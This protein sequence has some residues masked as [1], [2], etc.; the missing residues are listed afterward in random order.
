MLRFPK[1]QGK[2]FTS[3]CQERNVGASYLGH[4]KDY[5]QRIGRNLQNIHPFADPVRPPLDGHGPND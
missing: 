3:R 2:Q 5:E 1:D 4:L